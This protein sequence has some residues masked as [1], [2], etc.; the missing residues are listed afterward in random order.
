[1]RFKSMRMVLF[2]VIVVMACLIASSA[3]IL[4]AEADPQQGPVSFEQTMEWNK[5]GTQLQQA[6]LA[7]K[8]ATDMQRS[9]SCYARVRAP[10]TSGDRSFLQSKGFNVRVA[11][12]TIVRGD[13]TADNLPAVA[14]LPFVDSIKLAQPSSK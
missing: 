6:W 1:M 14:Q 12:G 9:F 8:K 3:F 7:A 4:S 10:Y 11:A 13:V 2:L 5:I